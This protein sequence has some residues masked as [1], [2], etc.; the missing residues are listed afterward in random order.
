M[1]TMLVKPWGEGQGDHVLIEE[2]DFDPEFHTRLDA[3]SA[4]KR[5]RKPKQVETEVPADSADE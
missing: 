4:P 5:G 1:A 3:E 2:E